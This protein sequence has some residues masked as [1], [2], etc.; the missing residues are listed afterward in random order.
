ME[1]EK[2]SFT[3]ILIERPVNQ[4]DVY[5][6]MYE[7]TDET[8][9]IYRIPSEQSIYTVSMLKLA[10]HTHNSVNIPV[11][12]FT[13]NITLNFRFSQMFEGV[14]PFYIDIVD[15]EKEEFLGI[16]TYALTDTD[17]HY[18]DR[19]INNP[20]IFMSMTPYFYGHKLGIDRMHS[21]IEGEIHG[22]RSEPKH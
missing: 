22:Y 14:Y 3:T 11:D 16:G 5:I 7:I 18:L 20:N 13:K 8:Y 15:M 1:T 10:A 2:H 12:T 19:Y 17:I 21:I 4:R 9:Q 6:G